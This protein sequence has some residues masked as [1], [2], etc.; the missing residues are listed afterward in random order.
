MTQYALNDRGSLEVITDDYYDTEILRLMDN[1]RFDREQH[2]DGLAHLVPEPDNP[3]A[4]GSIAVWVD[5]LKIARLSAED[6]RR[7]LPAIARV[8]VSGHDPVV[9]VRVW[10]TMRGKAG[11]VRLES[12]AVLSIARPDQLFPLNACPSRAA[13]LPQGPTLKVLDEKDH[14]EYLHSILPVSGEGRVILTLEAN[15]HRQPDGTETDSVD[16]LHDRRVVGRLSTQMSEQLAPVVRYAFERDKLTAAWG[17]I[18]GNA[19]ELSLSVQTARAEDLTPSWFEQLPHGLPP[20]V[21]EQEHYELEDAY[22]PSHAEKHPESRRPAAPAPEDPAPSARNA[23]RREAQRRPAR[24]RAGSS[25]A[26]RSPRAPRAQKGPNQ[27]I[28]WLIGVLGALVLLAGVVLL[29]VRPV[30]GILG[31]LLG[32]S[33]AFC[34]LYLARLDGAGQPVPA[35]HPALDQDPAPLEESAP[36]EDSQPRPASSDARAQDPEPEAAADAAGPD[37]PGEGYDWAPQRAPRRAARETE[38]S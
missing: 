8:V 33:L 34:G 31:L 7:Y 18:R 28:G 21:P 1:L 2:H 36:L 11:Q 29:F 12:R 24:R 19:F 4:P 23:P 5:G 13:L 6:S 27:R 9:P 14:A 30:L 32:G 38:G 16:V 10:A 17:T 15:R 37:S 26:P 3:H 22:R 25:S 20:L 35:R